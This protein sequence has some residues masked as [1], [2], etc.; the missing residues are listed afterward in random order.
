M[1]KISRYCLA[2]CLFTSFGW[3]GL[4][5]SNHLPIT[6]LPIEQTSTNPRTQ[7]I[8]QRLE[9]IKA[10]DRSNLSA[11]ERKALRQETRELKKAARGGVYLSVGAILII[12]LILILI[13]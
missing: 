2:L 13:L 10:L 4:Q 6:P 3:S 12:V 9:E 11:R 7:A 1:K 8:T 5:A